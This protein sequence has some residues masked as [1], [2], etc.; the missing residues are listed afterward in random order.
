MTMSCRTEGAGEG[1][2]FG[3]A[4]RL[5][6]RPRRPRRADPGEVLPGPLSP[7][8][9]SGR[10]GLGEAG[11]AAS[12]RPGAGAGPPGALKPSWRD[13]RASRQSPEG[14]FRKARPLA[15]DRRGQPSGLGLKSEAATGIRR[16]ASRLPQAESLIPEFTIVL[17]G[18][19]QVIDKSG[20]TLVEVKGEIRVFFGNGEQGV[21]LEDLDLE[22]R[23]F[24]IRV[25]DG[26]YLGVNY[27][28]MLFEVVETLASLPT[29][30][31]VID[32][33]TAT[34]SFYRPLAGWEGFF[35]CLCLNPDRPDQLV[36]GDLTEIRVAWN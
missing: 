1:P 22:F 26:Y 6:S 32:L 23:P 9:G 21:R 4:K 36:A 2:G 11:D 28:P 27:Q 13:T 19:E 30:E 3:P 16:Q 17:S 33:N 8:A 10:G 31:A 14:P 7:E 29:E 12:S 34:I 35:L 24:A 20:E 25:K 15:R 5:G 18:F